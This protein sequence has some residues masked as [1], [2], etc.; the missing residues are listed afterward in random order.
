MP[1]KPFCLEIG[2]APSVAVHQVDR[3]LLE[4]HLPPEEMYQSFARAIESVNVII[5]TYNDEL[6]GDVQVPSA[7]RGERL[8]CANCRDRSKR[9]RFGAE[10]CVRRISHSVRSCDVTARRAFSS[11]CCVCVRN[12]RLP[13]PGSFAFP[14]F[15]QNFFSSVLCARFFGLQVYPEQGTVA[16]G[17]GL[18]Q[19]GF[20]LKKFAKIYAAKFGTQEEKMMQ[21]LWGDWYFDAAGKKVRLRGLFVVVF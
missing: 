15:Y 21:K 3:A 2:G 12:R 5:A 13:P 9:I 6:L 14:D 7:R 8:L 4:L 11:T 10:H 20:T 17:S 19:W 16:F 1:S 18:H